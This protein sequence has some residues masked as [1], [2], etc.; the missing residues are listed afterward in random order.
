KENAA[1]A[2]I[3]IHFIQ[4]D[5]FSFTH[6]GK[7]DEILTEFPDLFHKEKE[8]KIT[9]L[10]SFFKKSMELTKS[11]SVWGMITGER[12]LMKQQIRMT[13]GITLVEEIPFGGH[14]TLY[15]CRRK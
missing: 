8:E 1:S 11:G 2:E 6:D 10:R 13:R 12:N 9:F 7:F 5:Y 15:I 14:R 4:R 3:P